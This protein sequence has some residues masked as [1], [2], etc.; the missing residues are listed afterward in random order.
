MKRFIFL[1]AA[2]EMIAV[3]VRCFYGVEVTD[4]AYY[5]ANANMLLQGK[6]PITDIWTFHSG[7]LIIYGWLIGLY[8]FFVPNL[9]SVFLFTRIAFTLFR[10]I[11]LFYGFL[12]LKKRI[13]IYPTLCICM[14]LIP[15]Y[16][17]IN[18]FSYN[19]VGEWG[20]LLTGFVVWNAVFD[21]KNRYLRLGI[22]GVLTTLA[23]CSHPGMIFNTFLFG[24]FYFFLK[25]KRIISL[26]VYIAGGISTV[27]FL[28][29]GIVIQSGGIKK[30]FYSTTRMITA[31]PQIIRP[32]KGD[33][34][35][36]AILKTKFELST[37]IFIIVLSVAVAVF[38][39]YKRK[40][41]IKPIIRLWLVCGICIWV[42]VNLIHD[43][44]RT[45]G[46]E[47]DKQYG[48]L[49]GIAS[50]CLFLAGKKDR[51]HV[52]LFLFFSC[53]AIIFTVTNGLVTSGGLYE[54]FGSMIPCF[55]GF[56]GMLFHL[57]EISRVRK[58]SVSGMAVALTVMLSAAVLAF[59][60]E[61]AYR[62]E[63]PVLLK[64]RVQK[65]IYKG[66][67]TTWDNRKTLQEIEEIVRRKT[68]KC[69]TILAMDCAPEIYLMTRAK[70]LAP[71]AWDNMHYADGKNDPSIMYEY[72]EFMGEIPDKIVYA[73]SPYKRNPSILNEDYLFNDFVNQYYSKEYSKKYKNDYELII[74]TLT[75][76]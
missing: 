49:A 66:L 38:I 37:L 69:Q 29:A 50:V 14:V 18:N 64:E 10:F 27:F 61:Y 40:E 39:S 42:A 35:V 71:S 47:T 33:T 4:E 9:E 20:A 62:E 58:E 59:D 74:Y 36:Q 3:I 45:I 17:F 67:Y 24:S 75:N 68:N 12:V 63:A 70:A 55:A 22:A 11:I 7:S 21:D 54:R 5:L 43:F 19:S 23:I 51:T 28:F 26:I 8:R 25:E 76:K 52:A 32:G 34:F 53:P 30:L 6:I 72:F 65:G 57:I 73:A 41:N 56:V 13:H 15:Y 1:L 31:T 46:N 44:Y 16:G 60:Y 48:I 2:I